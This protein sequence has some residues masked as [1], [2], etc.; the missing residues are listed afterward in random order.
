[1]SDQESPSKSRSYHSWYGGKRSQTWQTPPAFFE[2]L[3]AEY[4]FTLDGAS[5]A[6]NA[7]L[8]RASS[9]DEPASWEGE[10]VYCN[11]PW[12]NIRPFVE[13]AAQADLAVLL[14][15]ARTNCK[16]FHRAL[17]LGATVRFFRGKPKFVGARHVSPV[18]CVLLV[19]EGVSQARSAARRV[20]PRSPRGGSHELN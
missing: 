11:P 10:R 1:M 20:A 8:P 17:E 5:S 19:F 6:A 9:A 18:D 15:P 2:A 13:L 12:S 3:H 16:W 14:V 4:G 7:L